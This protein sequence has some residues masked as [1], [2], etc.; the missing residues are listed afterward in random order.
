MHSSRFLIVLL[1]HYFRVY[2]TF[3]SSSK[4]TCHCWFTRDICWCDVILADPPPFPHCL[5][6]SIITSASLPVRDSCRAR[7]VCFTV[8]VFGPKVTTVM[9]YSWK[10][11]NA[12]LVSSLLLLAQISSV[13]SEPWA[14]FILTF[15]RWISNLIVKGAKPSRCR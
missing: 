13:Q 15:G 14:P 2:L 12:G 8:A 9:C 6:H 10:K 3:Y 7:A 5:V 11:Q 1:N 4:D